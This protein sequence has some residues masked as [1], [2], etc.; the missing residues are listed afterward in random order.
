MPAATN[1]LFCR[2][3]AES[4]TSDG[5]YAFC[6]E[7]CR[8]KLLPLIAESLGR[9]ELARI[10]NQLA[11]TPGAGSGPKPMVPDATA[12]KLTRLIYGD[13]RGTEMSRGTGRPAAPSAP[14]R[15]MTKSE[16]ALA[17][18]R[19]QARQH[20][21]VIPQDIERMVAKAGLRVNGGA[22]ELS[23][24]AGTSTGT[25]ATTRTPARPAGKAKAPPSRSQIEEMVRR[26]GLDVA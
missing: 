20:N 10:A 22:T 5:R 7:C 23:T 21:E 25:A 6:R 4:K 14:W 15:R 3:A 2:R 26:A 18:A 8:S 11:T 13:R 24:T 16:Q 17:I 1:C 12:D 9:D 19:Y